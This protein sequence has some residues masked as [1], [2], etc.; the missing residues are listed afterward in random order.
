M[1]TK[2]AQEWYSYE[3]EQLGRSLAM[4][5]ARMLATPLVNDDREALDSYVLNIEKD[6]FIKGTT[7]FDEQ[8]RTIKSFDENYSVIQQFRVEESKPLIFIQDIVYN[9]QIV[10][11]LKLILDRDIVIQHHKAFNKNQLLQTLLIIFL[12][13]ISAMMLTRLFYKIRNRYKYED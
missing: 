13:T 8:G 5:A 7:L 11:Y 6:A 2:N 4:Q 3:A 9:G 1:H 12:T 10:G